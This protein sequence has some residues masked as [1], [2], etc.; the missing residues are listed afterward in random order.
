MLYNKFKI[1]FLVGEGDSVITQVLDKSPA[2]QTQHEEANKTEDQ[3]E[4]RAK[5]K[6]RKGTRNKLEYSKMRKNIK[7]TL[8]LR[9]KTPVNLMNKLIM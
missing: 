6:A 8:K 4:E 2:A 7:I 1:M 3:G 9:T 5:Q